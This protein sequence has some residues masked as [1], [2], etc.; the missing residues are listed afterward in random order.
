MGGRRGQL[1]RAEDRQRAIMLID[2]AVA[3]GAREAKACEVLVL[4]TRTLRRWRHQARTDEGCVDRRI[5]SMTAKTPPN[6]LTEEERQQMIAVCNQPEYQSLPPSQIVPILADQGTYIA[7][8]SSFYRVLRAENQLHHRGRAK[9]PRN[10]EKPKGYRADGPNQ[11][12]SWD[13]TYLAS[14]VK[15]HF[16]YL[17]LIMDIYSRK[18]VGW[19][20]H[21]EEAAQHASTLISRTYLREKVNPDQLVLHSDNGSPMKGATMLATL[22]QLGIMPSFSRPSVSDD[23]PFSES[24]FKTLK[25]IPFYPDK[26][27]ESLDASRQWVRRFVTWYNEEHRHSALCF[28]TPHQRHT[29]E[30]TGILANRA[31]LYQGAQQKN[32]H[33]WSGQ[34]RNWSLSNE[35]WLN[36]P[37]E[38]RAEQQKRQLAA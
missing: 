30:D 24:L 13:I 23:N 33:R 1:I 6:K 3:A 18:I 16:Y 7:S 15:G 36:P 8:E 9:A 4:S 2:E 12:Y 21:E 20:V 37:K 34:T 31:V 27:F 28:V 22:Q 17:Y 19:E 10:V 38:I 26:P 32:P 35:V 5:V 14:T 11:V 25:Y 29:G